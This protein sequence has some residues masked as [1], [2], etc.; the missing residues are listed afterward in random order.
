M[1]ITVLKSKIHRATVT[2]ADLNYEGSISIDKNLLNAAG[3]M[4]YEMVQ[5]VNLNNGARF[6]TYVIEGKAGSGEVMLNGPAARLG[7]VG[8]LIIIIAY[9]TIYKEEA[10]KFQ[11]T[12]IMVDSNNKPV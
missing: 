9:A 10:E 4:T 3:I 12:I 7:Q 6:E 11:P 8:D 5:V 2:G 1:M